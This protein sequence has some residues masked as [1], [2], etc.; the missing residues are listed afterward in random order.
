MANSKSLNYDSTI[1]G[2]TIKVR[3]RAA[4]AAVYVPGNATADFQLHAFN[5]ASRRRFGIHARGANLTRLTGTAPDQVRRRTF[6]PYG[7]EAALDALALDSEVTIGGVA[8]TVAAK[9]PETAN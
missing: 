2:S 5:G 8:W 9:V 7:T 1:L 6:L 3:L 4:E